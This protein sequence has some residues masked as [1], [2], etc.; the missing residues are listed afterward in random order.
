MKVIYTPHRGWRNQ[1]PMIDGEDNVLSLGGNNWNDFDRYMTLNASLI[2]NRQRFDIPLQLKLLIEGQNDTTQ[3]LNQLCDEG[4][5]GVFPIPGV[6]YVSVPS[7]IDFYKAVLSKLGEEEATDVLRSIRDAGFFVAQGD[8]DA[9][10]LVELTDFT[11]SLLR[12]SGAHKSYEDG[13]K[14]FQGIITEIKNFDL[15]F[16]CRQR[17]RKEIPFQFKSSLLPYDI[18]VLIGSN[19]VGKSHC[20]KTL[21]SGWLQPS[22]QE[23]E[24]FVSC[25]NDRPNFSKLILISYSP[26]EE[27]NLDLS[28]AKLLDKTTYKYF[29]FR[30]KTGVD[31]DGNIK[32]GINRHLPVLE[33][34]HSLIDAIYDDEKFS[35]IRNRVCKLE[36]AEEVLRPALK[37]DYCAF[38]I[39]LSLEVEA[40]RRFT[41]HIEGKDYLLVNEHIAKLVPIDTLKTACKLSEGVKFLKDGRVIGLSSG[42]RLF[43]YIVI[44]V[45]GAI[46][47]N[48]LVVIDEPELF[49]HPTLEIE[50]IALLKAVLKPFRSKAILAT[51]SLAVVREVPSNCVHI[52][53]QIDETLDVVPPPFETF[54]ASVQKISS[55]VFGDKSVTKPFDDWLKKLVENEPNVEK[56]IESLGDEINEQLMM[57]IL[58]LGRQAHGS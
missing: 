24:D 14:L 58:R 46:R 51:H 43:T 8:D 40:I 19:G 50:F 6:N 9:R 28:D 38:E 32:I 15:I 39:S 55:Y 41:T 2:F 54:G 10:R 17:Q 11:V 12:E 30:Q 7:D 37:Y 44:N 33:S 3:K 49:L 36:A 20:L 47:E 18:N 13:W 57:K 48:S 27:F 4:W 31:D 35:F 45:L 16:R 42:Q 22:E 29:G 1:P 26:F 5:D 25:F 56:L 52:F 53:R 34:S 23:N 21:V